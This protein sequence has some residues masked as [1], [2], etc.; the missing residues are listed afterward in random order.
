[1]TGNCNGRVIFIWLSLTANDRDVAMK[2]GLLVAALLVVT[3]LTAWAAAKKERPARSGKDWEPTIAAFEK[4]DKAQPPPR[5]AALFTGASHISRWKSLA[6]DFPKY[7]VINRGFG[8]SRISDVL[9]Y[10][11][12][13]VIPYAPRLVIVQAGGNDIRAGRKPEEVFA[14]FKAFVSKVRA[15]LPD[16]RIAY[17]SI[18]SSL[19][20]WPGREPFL[21]ANALIEEYLKTQ[22]NVRYIDTWTPMLGEDGQPRAELF[23]ADG[24]H[25]SKAGYAVYVR[26]IEPYLAG[27]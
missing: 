23:V 10:A 1:M 9:Q 11:D 12:R 26:V 4:A 3:L 7:Q 27:P 15:S 25:L 8:G 21:R 13:I 2:L 24:L 20:S 19:R 17:L 16:T 6:K 18:P 5:G 14:E 22:S